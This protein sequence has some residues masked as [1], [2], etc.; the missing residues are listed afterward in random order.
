M[1][2]QNISFG[3][4][5]EH[6]DLAAIERRKKLAE[7]LANQSVEPVQS[8]SPT[9]HISW[10]QGL[11]KMLQ[12]YT[13]GSQEKSA[14]EERKSYLDQAGKRQ[15]ADTALLA[16][17]LQGKPAQPAGMYE[18]ASSNVSP[19]PAT[20]A[21][22]PVQS[23]GQIMPMMGPHM[24]P[25][26]F[27]ALQG[28]QQRQEQR[29]FQAAQAKENRD[30]R[31]SDREMAVIASD[32]RTREGNDLRQT[33]ANQGDQTRRDLAAAQQ[34]N[35]PPIAVMGPDGKPVY[36]SADQ[37]VG[38]QPFNQKQGGGQLP[39]QALKMQN[40]LLDEIGIAGNIRSD[41]GALDGQL[42]TGALNIGPVTNAI[43]AARN[44]TGRSNNESQNYNTFKTTLERLRNDSLRLNKGVQTE[45]DAQRAWNELMGNTND[46]AVVRKRL[47][48]IQ[49]INE[50]GATLKRMQIDQIRSN[51]GV[52]PLD[53]K[54]FS[55]QGT[56]VTSAGPQPGGI[57]PATQ[58]L[59]NQ[60]APR[61][62]R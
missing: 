22:T 20:P 46:P 26:A 21:Q 34:S 38:R 51:Y 9:S 31:S 12:A 1:P 43:N 16:Q 55:N 61:N 13:A 28:E 4:Q 62:P 33:I 57:N 8:V 45:G 37:A 15:S 30:A 6:S 50:R 25:V 48:E 39:T 18:D 14:E 35:R 56:A 3:Q 7:A 19:M 42:A 41:I 29:D 17:A 2:T 54:D 59:L 49:N 5:Q 24:Q 44:F 23:I 32:Q 11:A 47:Q 40:E 36:V 53:T 27:Q 60:Y 58:A 10:T 52:D